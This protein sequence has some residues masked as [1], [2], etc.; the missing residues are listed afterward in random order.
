MFALSL[1]YSANLTRMIRQTDIKIREH[2][3]H[4][5]I[6]THRQALIMN[7]DRFYLTFE[8]IEPS[9]TIYIQYLTK[10]CETLIV[11]NFYED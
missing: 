5:N 1:H 4:S 3:I 7:N 10:L 8:P 11:E 9:K 2:L 6:N